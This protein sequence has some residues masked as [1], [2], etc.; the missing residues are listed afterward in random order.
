MTLHRQRAARAEAQQ[1][2]A[3]RSGRTSARA[4][5]RTPS[6]RAS[7]D[8]LRAHDRG[9]RRHPVGGVG[10]AV[11]STHWRWASTI[12]SRVMGPEAIETAR[13]A[14]PAPHQR[15]AVPGQQ[16]PADQ[17]RRGSVKASGPSS[18]VN[19][20]GLVGQQDQVGAGS[21]RSPDGRPW[22]SGRRGRRTRCR[23]PSRR[24]RSPVNVSRPTTIHGSRQ[25]GTA[26]R[27][28]RG[29]HRSGPG[30]P[31]S[32][33]QPGTPQPSASVNSRVERVDRLRHRLDDRSPTRHPGPR[34]RRTS[35]SRFSS[36][37]AITRSGA[38]ARIAATSGF[39]VPRTRATS[40]SAGC[41]HQSVAPTSAPGRVTAT[42]SVSDGH[43]R[44]HPAHRAAQQD[45]GPQVVSH[46]PRLVT[47][48]ERRRTTG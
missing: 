25:I 27:A 41:V 35:S 19:D 12:G 23:Q 46:A 13:P 6:T 7:S 39:F 22:G 45:L 3:P 37:L 36:W 4:G 40:R 18:A 47:T 34:R 31:A 2:A 29:G 15:R 8:L 24:S 33:S 48:R 16:P 11:G 21:R 42:A 5:R 28:A 10:P 43:Q 9:H 1:H 30:G 14:P 17:P 32:A 20:V 44:D 26:T 38:R